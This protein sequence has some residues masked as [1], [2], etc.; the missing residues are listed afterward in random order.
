MA[1]PP[2]L[3]PP[4]WGA[5]PPEVNTARLQAGA[6]PA[7]MLQAAAGWEALAISLE[8]QADELAAA[9]ASL[10]QNWQGTGADRAISAVMPMIVWLRMLALQAQKR[11]LQAS[12]QASAYTTAFAA[13]PQLPEIEMNHVTHGVLE[14]TNFLGV[15]TVPIGMNEADYVRMWDLAATVMST[16]QAE[17]FTNATFE[18]ITPPKP[19]VVPGGAEAALATGLTGAAPGMASAVARNATIA[20]VS[21]SGKI[22]EAGQKAGHFEGAANQAAQQAKSPAEQ[23]QLMQQGPQMA[24]QMAS[25]VGST[26]AQAPQ[27]LMQGVTQPFQQ[28][29]QPLQQM[30]SLFGQMGMGGDKSA[31][32]GMLG[33]TPFSNHPAIGGNGPAAGA[34]LVRAASLPGAGGTSARTPLMSNLVGKE[35]QPNLSAVA[36]GAAAGGAAAG[37]APVGQGSGAGGGPMG[38]MGHR[39]Q[40]GAGGHR[41][42]LTAPAPLDYDLDEDETDDW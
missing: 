22:D 11:A 23:G 15:N 1:A 10:A 38:M 31:Q 35:L 25:Q 32:V 42:S 14:S 4:V 26:L 5:F 39:G 27:Q 9:M 24:M 20:K 21:A 6:G 36:V 28:L 30:S 13:T 18:P 16:Y 3:V 8:T 40:G 7:P 34:G 37:L 29:T 33:A 41:G 2:I 12:A 19:I 17:T